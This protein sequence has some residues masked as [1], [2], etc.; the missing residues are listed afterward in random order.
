MN[1]TKP[2]ATNSLGPHRRCG[3]SW[4]QYITRR[5]NDAPDANYQARHQ[6]VQNW[7]KRHSLPEGVTQEQYDEVRWEKRERMEH[8]LPVGLLTVHGYLWRDPY[9]PRPGYA[10]CYYA[11]LDSKNRKFC[12]D[13][14]EAD[15][16]TTEPEVIEVPYLLHCPRVGQ[17]P[18]LNPDH[19]AISLR[20]KSTG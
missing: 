2:E 18:D 5:I 4:E 17:R 15:E 3:E 19:C 7:V 9:G 1:Q 12:V 14:W 10:H 13:E 11:Y 8:D 16:R 20:M 6:K